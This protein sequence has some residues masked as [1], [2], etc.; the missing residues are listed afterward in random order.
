MQ[1]SF[2]I[3]VVQKGV[4][5]GLLSG[6]LFQYPGFL[7]MALAGMGA[8]EVLEDPADWLSAVSAGL[9]AAG[10]ALVVDA[11]YGLATKIAADR[12][13]QVYKCVCVCVERAG[14]CWA[15]SHGLG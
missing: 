12:D 10:V 5:G 2:A 15:H 1:V 14:E 7:I 4:L 11:C 9:S 13:T 6:S 3:G 8:A